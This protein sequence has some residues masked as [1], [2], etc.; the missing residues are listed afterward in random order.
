M[1]KHILNTEECFFCYTGFTVIPAHNSILCIRV[2]VERAL[3]ITNK[4][5]NASSN[6]EKSNSSENFVK[7][8]DKDFPPGKEIWLVQNGVTIHIFLEFLK[9]VEN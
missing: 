8:V 1:P 5:E 6:E 4:R 3:S 9:N 7:L 2:D